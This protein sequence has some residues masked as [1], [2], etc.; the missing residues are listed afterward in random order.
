MIEQPLLP[1]LDDQSESFFDYAA[2]GELRVQACEDCGVRRMPPRPRCDRCGSFEVRWD[3]MSGRGTI[4][5]HVTPHPPLLPAYS[6]QA[7]YN[8]VLVELHD[9]PMIRLVG[10]VVAAADAAL[11][12]VDP[13]SIAI[14]MPV[15]VVFP[16]AID[17]GDGAVVL[18]RWIAE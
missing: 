6:E 7:P 17:D 16:P 13:H 4:W 3:H 1:D 12:S 14:G 5:S 10:N 8:V 15:Q 2:A 18:P 9:D 11:D